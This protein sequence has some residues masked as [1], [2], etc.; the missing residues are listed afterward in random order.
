MGWGDGSPTPR[1]PPW[2]QHSG[3]HPLKNAG[4]SFLRHSNQ[5][6]RKISLSKKKIFFLERRM[7][8]KISTKNF[9]F[10]AHLPGGIR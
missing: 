1:E 7:K 5:L 4:K 2:V 10:P 6:W 3:P 8:E 9:K